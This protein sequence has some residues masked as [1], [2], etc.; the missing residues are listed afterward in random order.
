MKNMQVSRELPLLVNI[1]CLRMKTQKIPT[2][3]KFPCNQ[4]AIW[5]HLPNKVPIISFEIKNQNKI[6][7]SFTIGSWHSKHLLAACFTI[8]GAHQRQAVLSRSNWTGSQDNRTSLST[9]YKACITTQ[10]G[11]VWSMLSRVNRSMM[12]GDPICSCDGTSDS[13]VCIWGQS[14]EQNMLKCLCINLDTKQ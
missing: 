8:Q 9:K 4:N 12:H 10:W 14:K 3:L 6:Q 7:I 2:S 11:N 1:Q 13:Q 5:S